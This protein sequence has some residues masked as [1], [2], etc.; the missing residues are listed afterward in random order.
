[1][2]TKTLRWNEKEDK[3]R[4]ELRE[5]ER[6]KDGVRDYNN[7]NYERFSKSRIEKCW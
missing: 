2:M 6:E 4:E 5:S 1:M 7:D 3:K